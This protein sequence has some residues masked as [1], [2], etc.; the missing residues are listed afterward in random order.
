M[1]CGI[2]IIQIAR[3]E[4]AVERSGQRFLEPSILRPQKLDVCK[5]SMQRL[6]GRLRPRKRCLRRWNRFLERRHFLA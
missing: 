4:Q 5:D 1:R 3:I 6:A 2:D